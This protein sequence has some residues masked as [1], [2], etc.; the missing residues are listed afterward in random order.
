MLI[1]KC[2]APVRWSDGKLEQLW[3]EIGIPQVDG[4]SVYETGKYEWR[5]VP[6]VKD[7][8][9]DKEIEYWNGKL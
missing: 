1:W 5:V 9:K 3:V 6:D 2:K 4:Y 7:I 8:P